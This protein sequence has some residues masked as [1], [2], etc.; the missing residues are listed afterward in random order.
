MMTGDPKLI[1]NKY[2]E[3]RR[4]CQNGQHVLEVSVEGNEFECIYCEKSFGSIHYHNDGIAYSGFKDA[5]Y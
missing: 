4:K 1:T 2:L 3:N 5:K